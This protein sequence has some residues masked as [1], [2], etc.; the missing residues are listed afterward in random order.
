MQYAYEHKVP[1]LGHNYYRLEQVDIDG[2]ASIHQKIVDLIWAANG[3]TVSIYPNPTQD[4]LQ[5]D[6]Y[7]VKEQNTTIKIM[8]MSGR[9]IKQVQAKSIKGLNNLSIS[10]G[11]FT[12]GV[13]TVQIFENNQ[14]TQVSKVN[15]N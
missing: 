3:S 11:E 13:Y 5:I 9:I 7:T 15:K 4:V 6:L 8:D 12:N 1:T 2:K 14:L 10:L